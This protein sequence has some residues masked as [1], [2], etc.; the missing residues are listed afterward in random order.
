MFCLSNSAFTKDFHFPVF[1]ISNCMVEASWNVMAHAEKP[2]FVFRG[3]GRVH[4]NR[5]GRQ[6][7]RLQAA[8]MCASAVIML[9][10]TCSEVVWRV[11]STHSI[12]QFTLPCVTVC[13]HI[14]TGVYYF[15]FY[16]QN[17]PLCHWNTNCN[18]RLDFFLLNFV[19][20]LSISQAFQLLSWTLIL[21][22]FSFQF[23][24]FS[25]G[26]H[27]P[28]ILFANIL[29]TAASNFIEAIALCVNT[30]SKIF[31]SYTTINIKIYTIKCYKF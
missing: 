31:T 21:F 6:F 1:S 12:R 25:G 11:L 4:L 18:R 16:V 30:I 7:T 17:F 10:K 3:N 14:S 22:Y 8:E 28:H 27:W 2:E 20:F 29:K 5:P 23:F 13:H 26:V 19:H 9:D 15:C 24:G